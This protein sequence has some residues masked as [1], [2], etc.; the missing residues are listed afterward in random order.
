[1]SAIVNNHRKTIAASH[2]LWK[3]PV[4]LSTATNSKLNP[5]CTLVDLS[6]VYI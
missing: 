4:K 5:V 3:D 2:E 1:M 6:D